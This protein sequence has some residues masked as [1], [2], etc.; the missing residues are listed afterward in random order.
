ML[1]EA[2][3]IANEILPL[4]SGYCNEAGGKSS[5]LDFWSPVHLPSN[6]SLLLPLYIKNNL[7][8]DF[9]HLRKY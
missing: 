8:N 1:P 6:K 4:P 7:S 5:L 2:Q 9:G 3:F